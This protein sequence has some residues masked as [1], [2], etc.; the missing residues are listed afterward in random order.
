MARHV[1]LQQGQRRL[2][3][4]CQLPHSPVSICDHRLETRP[5]IQTMPVQGIHVQE[6]RVACICFQQMI[7]HAIENPGTERIIEIDCELPRWKQKLSGILRENFRSKAEPLAI[8]CGG[9]SQFGGKLH[10]DEPLESEF[11]GN[12]QRPAF[13]A[14]KID[15]GERRPI[16]LYAAEQSAQGVWIHGLITF[17]AGKIL[18]GNAQMPEPN[19]S[20]RFD[21]QTAVEGR[22]SPA[23]AAKVLNITGEFPQHTLEAVFAKP[24]AQGPRP[25]RCALLK[26]R[27]VRTELVRKLGHGTT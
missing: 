17:R 2:R 6:I 1:P 20:C 26:I 21:S 13:A 15:E 12:D 27:K 23:N 10:A 24:H 11:I 22:A 14:A 25:A 9:V 18:G 3:L 19:W 5:S 4:R 16:G 7:E 8:S